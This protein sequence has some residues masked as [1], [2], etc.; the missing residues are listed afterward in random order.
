[1]DGA[2]SD[3]PPLEIVVLGYS[4][5]FVA[6]ARALLGVEGGHAND[7]LDR[8]GETQFGISLRFLKAEGRIDLDGDGIA[9]FDLDLDGDIDGRD[10]RLLTKGDAVWLFHECFWKRLGCEQWFAPIGEALFDQ[11]VNGGAL[12]AK[13]LLQ[14]AINV[15]L[16]AS[17]I[18]YRPASLAVDGVLGEK[19]RA[20]FDWVYRLPALGPSALI[21]V[22]RNAAA[23]RYRAIVAA[24]PSQKRFLKGWLARAAALGKH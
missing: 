4:P 10:I 6:A 24:D 23:D 15:C 20:A 11:A 19:T 16:A 12:A 21:I 13:K 7:P 2:N 5:R 9:D 8:G 3:N 18:N 17:R 14:R 22:Y 1:M